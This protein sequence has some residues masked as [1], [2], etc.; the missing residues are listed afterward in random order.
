MAENG[1]LQG[2]G[3]SRVVGT[4][5][6]PNINGSKQQPEVQAEKQR[7][8]EDV[9][10]IAGRTD[11][12]FAAFCDA[13]SGSADDD[14]GISGGLGSGAREQGECLAHLVT[15]GPGAAGG[16]VAAVGRLKR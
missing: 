7:M 14:D 9:W 10:L 15:M 3:C 4:E 8:G 2:G 1:L 6:E 16:E 11:N 13:I 12:G 5:Q